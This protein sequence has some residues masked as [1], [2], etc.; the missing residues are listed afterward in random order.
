MFKKYIFLFV[1]FLLCFTSLN[2]FAVITSITS[3]KWTQG[4]TWSNG[5][6]PQLTDTVLVQGHHNISLSSTNNQCAH[7]MLKG[8]LF[9]SSAGRQLSC[10][11]LHLS[12]SARIINKV[13]GSV[14]V[15]S[16]EV[17]GHNLIE[18][19][20]LRVNH[21][22][23][24][25]QDLIFRKTSGTITLGGVLINANGKWDASQGQS[26]SLSGD[27]ENNGHFVAGSGHYQ[28]TGLSHIKGRSITK[29]NQLSLSDTLMISSHL[30]VL[31]RAFAL[32]NALLINKSTGTLNLKCTEANFRIKKLDLRTPG[33]L[34]I[35]S[36]G[37]KQPLPISIEN[38]Y[39]KLLITSGTH[40][41][42]DSLI[43]LNHTLI[44]DTLSELTINHHINHH[45]NHPGAHE[46]VMRKQAKLT[47]RHTVSN[48]FAHFFSQFNSTKLDSVSSIV[49]QAVKD[50]S[51]PVLSFA[52]FEVQASTPIIVS[53]Q[54]SQIFK[55]DLKL[56]SK[57][58]FV[59]NHQHVV[60]KGNGLGSGQ[61]HN[62]A[63]SVRYQGTSR[64]RI[65]PSDYDSLFLSNSSGDTSMALGSYRVNMLKVLQGKVQ[66]GSLLI[67]SLIVEQKGT[68]Y[69]GSVNLQTT[70]T[71]INRGNFI[72]NS[73]TANCSF[74]GNIVNSGFFINNSS[75][76]HHLKASV[77]NTGLF[78]GC[79]GTA[80]TWTIPADVSIKGIARISFPRILFTG[81]DTIFNE[82]ELEISSS[83][84]GQGTLVNLS[85]SQ[86][87]LGMSNDQ[88]Q[89]AINAWEHANNTVKYN[90]VGDQNLHTV[91]EKTYQNL[92][93]SN[94]GTKTLLDHTTI[95]ADLVVDTG[96]VF[97]TKNHILTVQD[98]SLLSL[99][100]NS[101]IIIGSS[102]AEPA[103]KFPVDFK[104]SHVSIHP[105]AVVSYES[106]GDQMISTIPVY[107]HLHIKDGAVTKSFKKLDGG[108]SLHIRGDFKVL[109]SSVDFIAGNAIVEVGGDWLGP[110]HA[111]FDSGALILNGNAYNTGHLSV[112]SSPVFYVGSQDQEMKN[113][114]YQHLF[115]NKPSGTA[116]VRAGAGNFIVTKNM[117][118]EQGKVQVMGEEFEVQDS[119]I[120][121]DVLSFTSRVQNKT[122]QH[123]WVKNNGYLDNSY[124]IKMQI[125]GNVLVEGHWMNGRQSIIYFDSDSNQQFTSKHLTIFDQLIFSGS[126]GVKEAT[127]KG[128]LV[129]ND[130][131]KLQACSLKL[132]SATVNLSFNAFFSGESDQ[133]QLTGDGESWVKAVVNLDSTAKDN[134]AGIGFY[135]NADTIL[136]AALLTRGFES[137]LLPLGLYSIKKSYLLE[138]Q[139]SSI[140]PYESTFFY[141]N[142]ELIHHDESLLKVYAD[143]DYSNTF[144][145]AVSVV[146]PALNQ[147]LYEK[148]ATGTR[149]TLGE[150]IPDPL[151]VNLMSFNAR[152][153]DEDDDTPLQSKV[154]LSWEVGT[155]VNVHQYQLELSYDGIQF[156]L[157]TEVN[158]AKKDTEISKHSY[159]YQH[160]LQ[161]NTTT[162]QAEQLYFKLYEQNIW[163]EKKHLDTRVLERNSHNKHV[164][165]NH[166]IYYFPAMQSSSF[167]LYDLTGQLITHATIPQMRVSSAVVNQWCVL[168]SF[169]SMHSTCKKIYLK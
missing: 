87:I 156:D 81:N 95:L 135:I 15:D 22:L 24:V 66:L 78:K 34:L 149:M 124:G 69:V 162:N 148:S 140:R 101:K 55:G 35:L 47:F 127:I 18:K 52:N 136:G 2:L 130:S 23:T 109:E 117:V 147:V 168:C 38:Q 90:K 93:T 67:G 99:K 128:S 161:Q 51:L 26:F 126:N 112:G 138:L 104:R 103:V 159:Q 131:I 108:D 91:N 64:Q 32:P 12:D 7:L 114:H 160:Q 1:F 79:Q 165:I 94:Q 100:S 122:I 14:V 143:G 139:D 133:N 129:V 82:G 97:D 167:A 6:V 106:K 19:C 17:L 50:L 137:L 58:S 48:S 37:T 62:T 3:G 21:L 154:L 119:L 166:Q 59:I 11:S 75:S 155:E 40:V 152:W 27:F 84:T 105:S 151:P 4:A 113:A 153:H 53:N 10:K 13:L 116:Q 76:N 123:V 42:I 86:L 44:V 96:V 41:V 169:C 163:G 72:I 39:D 65:L 43:N 102:I 5:Q 150:V 33:N 20:N 61:F 77:H 92:T 88:N 157:L 158:C 9:F 145:P 68:V 71:L 74:G 73:N 146:N 46:F 83:I 70:N 60:I 141:R 142:H 45:I 80:C 8:L 16:L 98:S 120:L 121:N 118:V 85:N 29:F 89:A 28:F 164:K 107:G 36:R 134:I 132:D 30:Q 144:N 115:V 111:Y 31:T 110:G 49:V 57:V 63:G 54:G 56:G 125:K 25:H